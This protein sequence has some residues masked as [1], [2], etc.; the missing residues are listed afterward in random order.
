MILFIDKLI[1]YLFPFVYLYYLGISAQTTALLLL[2]IAFTS[3]LNAYTYDKYKAVFFVILFINL[4]LACFVPMYILFL[5]IILYDCILQ[6]PGYTCLLFA[7]PAANIWVKQSLSTVATADFHTTLPIIKFL[8]LLLALQALTAY[9]MAKKTRTILEGK[10]KA[11]RLQDTYHKQQLD[12]EHENRNLLQQQND[13]INIATLN[14]RNRIAREIHD[15][16]G[17]K[18]GRA[19]V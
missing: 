13:E 15:N 12:L 3:L 16:V 17:H 7:I 2:S 10:R 6:L 8:L 1:L 14:E 9:T 5:P 4:V 11:H 19:H 18:I